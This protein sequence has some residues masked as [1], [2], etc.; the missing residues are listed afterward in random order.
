MVEGDAFNLADNDIHIWDGMIR[1]SRDTLC[2][3]VRLLSPDEQK[4]ANRFRFDIDQKRYILGRAGLRMLLARYLKREAHALYFE[5]SHL[6]K[7]QLDHA[8]NTLQFNLSH[9]GEFILYGFSKYREIGIDVERIQ[10]LPERE[11]MADQILCDQER[12]ILQSLPPSAR[13][14]AFLSFWTRKESALKAQGL[15]IA[16]AKQVDV[17]SLSLSTYNGG[18]RRLGVAGIWQFY[19]LNPNPNYLGALATTDR[20]SL[21]RICRFSLDFEYLYS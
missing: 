11:A 17:S 20:T 19:D 12:A 5:Y 3:L 18:Y 4:R 10:A 6:G 8:N 15:G 9:S 1:C 21:V 2:S 13:D 14:R 7:P 16:E